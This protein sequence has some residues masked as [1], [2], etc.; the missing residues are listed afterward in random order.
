MFFKKNTQC[1][2]NRV[3]PEIEAQYCPDC[4]KYVENKWYMTRCGCCNIKRKTL[5]KG[6]KIQP[7]TKFCPNC[8]ASQFYLELIPSINFI[9]INFAVLV[10]EINEAHIST[11]SQIWFE[12]DPEPMKLLGYGMS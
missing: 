6:N 9:D 11:Q 2:H 4:G 3:S 8:G 7:Y 5:V 1:V 12:R 10:K